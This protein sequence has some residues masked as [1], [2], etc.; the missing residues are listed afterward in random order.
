MLNAE[1]QFELDN[2]IES[3]WSGTTNAGVAADRL[4]EYLRDAVQAH[5]AWAGIKLNEAT[6][7]GLV[8]MVKRWR[9]QRTVPVKKGHTPA[10]VGVQ[11]TPAE[12]GQVPLESLTRDQ[13]RRVIS[14]RRKQILGLRR[15]IASLEALQRLLDE[16][17]TAQ[18]VGDALKQQRTTLVELMEAAA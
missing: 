5:R 6:T 17:P 13:V 11:L 18:T 1:E 3:A 16:H 10:V 14:D 8:D 9:K 4:A 2:A 7:R 15:S 12:W